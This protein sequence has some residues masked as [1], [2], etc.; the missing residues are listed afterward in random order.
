MARIRRLSAKGAERRKNVRFITA[1]RGAHKRDESL[2]LLTAIRDRLMLAESAREARKIIKGRL[3]KVD[4]KTV[5]DPKRG[6]GLFDTLEVG[7]KTYRAV[8]KKRIE[9]VESEAG[10]KLVQVIGKTVIKGGK[11]QINLNDGK[12]IAAE[13]NAYNVLDSLLITLPDQKVKEHIPLEPGALVLIKKGAHAGKTAK[14]ID[15]K[16]ERKRVWLEEG[17]QKFEAP[18]HGVMAVG[19]DKPLIELGD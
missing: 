13:T 17:G 15:M 5:T 10:L 18:L 9:L 4:G 2:A 12:N 3:V 16:R 6:I 14:L 7:G 19:K 11:I 1:S 8:P